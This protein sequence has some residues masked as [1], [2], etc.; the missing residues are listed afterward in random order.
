MNSIIKVIL[1]GILFVQF[2]FAETVLFYQKPSVKNAAEYLNTQPTVDEVAKTIA[3]NALDAKALV[4]IRKK[5]KE[6][7]VS[8]TTRMPSIELKG[9]RL[10]IKGM[11]HPL[12]ISN[13]ERLEI[14]YNGEIVPLKNPTDIEQTFKDVES[15]FG[16]NRKSVRFIF[17]RMGIGDEAVAAPFLI[18]MAFLAIVTVAGGVYSWW[19]KNKKEGIEDWPFDIDNF[20]KTIDLKCESDRLAI[21]CGNE[22]LTFYPSESSPHNIDYRDMKKA[23]RTGTLTSIQE[24]GMK[25]GTGAF[26]NAFYSDRRKAAVLNMAKIALGENGQ[27]QICNGN[28]FAED[29]APVYTEI[30]KQASNQSKKKDK[31]GTVNTLKNLDSG[32]QSK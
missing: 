29:L 25:K 9:N 22:K 8:V 19:N 10:T 18:Y 6:K 3:F 24:T 2:S 16:T 21:T 12:I 20:G 5:L 32:S 27:R 28:E 4:T 14:S 13:S 30:A 31:P 17:L 26:T 15:F 7:G 23:N 11:E 1:S